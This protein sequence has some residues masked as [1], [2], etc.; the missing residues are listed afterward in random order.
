MSVKHFSICLATV[1]IL[2]CVAV[3]QADDLGARIVAADAALGS[4]QGE[5]RV[6]NSGTVSE[7]E[8]SLALWHDLI[9]NDGVTIFLNAGSYLY[10]NSHTRI[11][12]CII[13]ATS[14]PILGEV[15][16]VNTEYVELDSVTF[17][18]GGNLVYWSGVKNFHI[19]DNH[20]ASITAFDPITKTASVGYFLLGCS[21]GEIDNLVVS[22]FLFPAGLNLTGVLELVLS[23][24]ITVNNPTISGVDASYVYDG[25]GAIVMQG[26]GHIVINGGVIT[27][28]ANMDGV[29]S[30]SYQNN[31][32]SSHLTITGLYSSYNGGVGRNT[33]AHLGLGDGLDLINT[34]HIYVSHCMLNGNG[35]LHDEQ[36]GIWLFL[37][38]D[39]L[40]ADSDIS[41]GSMAGI[42]AAGS[43][44]VRLLRDTINNNQATGVFTEWQG[45]TAT[46]VGPAVTF[47][48][49][50]SGGFGLAWTPGTPFILDGVA[51]PIG[52]V[53][54]SEH[55]TLATSP[56]NHSSP[57]NWSVNSTQKVLDSVINDNGLGKFGG[58]IQVGI[59]W[60]DGTTG[61]IS[62]VTATDTGAGTQLYGLEL[63]NTA[64]AILYNDNFSGN[65]E[66]GDGINASS[67]GVSPTRLWFPNEGIA[68]TSPAQTV[69]LTA[70]AIVVQNLLVQ[71]SADFTET[72]NC[73]AQLLAFATCQI[74]VTFTPTT[75]G[76][77]NGTLTITDSA[78]N[79]PQA[80][81]LTGAGVAHGLGLSIAT[82]G[83]NSATIADGTTAKYSLSL[84]GAGMSG[85]A[86]L[87]CAGAPAGATCNV[88]AAEVVSAS[89][90]AAF[91][92]SVT[93]TGATMGKLR[94]TD[95]RP[96]PWLWSLAMMGWVVL[97]AGVGGTRR[98]RCYLLWLPLVLLMFLCSCS[99]ISN[100]GSSNITPAGSY[101]LTV[102]AKVGSTS[103]QLQLTLTIK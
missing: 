61:T 92:A 8:V 60:A 67:Q 80:V 99:G 85:T 37:D 33:K 87:T 50:V 70:G 57:V 54:D 52:S 89:Q 21:H 51:Y 71:A 102:T 5:I 6:T 66:G 35:S 77:H 90:S 14:T 88:P 64:S 91:N 81:P 10:Q 44:N 7:G 83:S 23:H 49:G 31:V 100:G 56:T 75:A 94:P 47:S 17:V 36:P 13:S 76:T 62:G 40:V 30:Q 12:N 95:F 34:R 63:A 25:A 29:L 82:G 98:S 2:G 4:R 28:N 84:G 73:G 74:Q 42:A 16:S 68:T 59:S 19:S 69:T 20:V 65:V 41:N 9:C 48:A 101:T 103:E 53:T 22:G 72:N 97:P 43:R 45:G 38:D 1:M 58:Q 39:V 24:H 86:S 11:K 32:R 93:T 78:P 18:G 26:S 27:G 3:G 15:Q 46:N 96:H 79:S 55:L